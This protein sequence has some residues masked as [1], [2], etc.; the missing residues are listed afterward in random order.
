[1][2]LL[3]C[4]GFF[5]L[6]D[7][8]QVQVNKLVG[9]KWMAEAILNLWLKIYLNFSPEKSEGA[10]GHVWELAQHRGQHL[11]LSSELGKET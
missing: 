3:F 4:V 10:W 7:L 1:M 5:F 2:F 8:T 11:N 9:T 6:A